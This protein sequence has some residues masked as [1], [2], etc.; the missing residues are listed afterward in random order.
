MR[1]LLAITYTLLGISFLCAFYFFRPVLET[2]DKIAIIV[3]P[4]I[5]A[6]Y[7]HFQYLYY[8][9]EERRYK[10][11]EALN[12]F[13]KRFKDLIESKNSV[14]YEQ[15]TNNVSWFRI[16]DISIGAVK[17]RPFTILRDSVPEF[18]SGVIAFQDKAI[19]ISHKTLTVEDKGGFPP[20]VR[21]D[22]I[23]AQGKQNLDDGYEAWF[24]QLDSHFGHYFSGLCALIRSVE[25]EKEF[26]KDDREFCITR[27]KHSLS[28]GEIFCLFY[29]CMNTELLC[30]ELK[31]YVEKYGLFEN[32]SF[33]CLE[34]AKMHEGRFYDP[35]AFG[36]REVIILGHYST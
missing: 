16:P 30:K 29:Y 21:Y 20:E 19:S 27:I 25:K 36:D 1:L 6:I 10:K 24:E 8:R 28:G 5:A 15:K 34:D 12:D 18:K 9:N 11:E 14:G 23:D 26:N 22:W 7:A 4:A 33:V 35:S 13:E 2:S 17:I 3:P 31:C 32:L